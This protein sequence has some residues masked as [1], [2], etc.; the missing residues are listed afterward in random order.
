MRISIS[1]LSMSWNNYHSLTE[2]VTTQHRLPSQAVFIN[3][4]V[5]YSTF[6]LYKNVENGMQKNISLDFLYIDVI[7]ANIMNLQCYVKF[8]FASKKQKIKPTNK[9][10]KKLWQMPEQH[11][12]KCK[13]HKT[14]K[15]FFFI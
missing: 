3:K 1:G 8:S 10:T 12:E 6:T 11:T 5:E 9:Q 2:Y 7:T 14:K 4:Q 13:I 15:F